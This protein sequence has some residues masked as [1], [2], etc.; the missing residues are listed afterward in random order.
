MNF[1]IKQD[2]DIPHL[3]S[4]DGSEYVNCDDPYYETIFVLEEFDGEIF[5][6]L[7]N[8]DNRVLGS[9]VVLHVAATSEVNV[10]YVELNRIAGYVVQ[11][12][13]L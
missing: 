1:C 8:S 12:N 10:F 11:T 6:R 2:I 5:Q 13:V 3:T 4:K 9:P 7:K